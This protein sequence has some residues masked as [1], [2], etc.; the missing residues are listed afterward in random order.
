MFTHRTTARR[1]WVTWVVMFAGLG[2]FAFPFIDERPGLQA[3]TC[4]VTGGFFALGAISALVLNP[5]WGIELEGRTLRWWHEGKRLQRTI[6]VDE[7]R[8]VRVI[9]DADFAE[10]ESLQ[11][12]LSVPRDCL[13]VPAQ[14]WAAGLHRQFPHI[15]LR[16]E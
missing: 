5:S 8:A 6:S 12:P 11:G 16:V 9:H 13:K 1:H 15:E 14:E 2:L 7:L 10:L 3:W 4:M